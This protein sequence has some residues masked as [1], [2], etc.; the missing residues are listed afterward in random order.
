MLLAFGYSEEDVVVYHFR[1]P[2]K[3]LIV[4]LRPLGTDNDILRMISYVETNK[5]LDVYIQ[6]VS[7]F[8]KK[9]V[10]KEPEYV[11][12]SDEG[13]YEDSDQQDEDSESY[14]VDGSY[15]GSCEG[16]AGEGEKA[17]GVHTT[18][19]KRVKSFHRKSVKAK[20]RKDRTIQVLVIKLVIPLQ[21]KNP[22]HYLTNLQKPYKTIVVHM[23]QTYKTPTYGPNLQNPQTKVNPQQT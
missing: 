21:N 17:E 6:H 11:D 15:E 13:S 2:G 3:Y 14:S 23:D 7:R 4:G 20:S 18:P 12:L 10:E 22:I 8:S 9:D 1:V 16:S 5:V 19:R